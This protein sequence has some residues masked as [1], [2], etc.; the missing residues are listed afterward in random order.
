MQCFYCVKVMCTGADNTVII[1]KFA[2]TD[3]ANIQTNK[4]INIKVKK[5]P[6]LYHDKMASIFRYKKMN[7]YKI[8]QHNEYT[9]EKI[10]RAEIFAIHIIL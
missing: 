4:I 5:K 2:A 7:T 6:G 1:G 10:R 9:G 3:S 8:I